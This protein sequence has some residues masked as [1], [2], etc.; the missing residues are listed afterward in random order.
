LIN[1]RYL[2][3]DFGSEPVD[4]E[5]KVEDILRDISSASPVPGGG[6]VAALSGSFGC[7]LISM[8]CNLTIGKT[9]Y[10][11]VESEFKD[12]LNE[13]EILKRELLDLSKKDVAAFNDVMASYK[14]SDEQDK[15]KKLQ[16]AYKNA[17]NVPYQTAKKCL[18]GLELAEISAT[19]G[20]QNAITDAGVG[21][22]LAYC[23]FQ[24]AILNV[25][26]NLKYT[27]DETFNTKMMLDIENHEKKA[28]DLL[29]TILD[30]IENT[31]Y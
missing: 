5:A 11:D 16:D 19:K 22:L 23:G 29:I 20:N 26:V 24:G 14:I 9:K 10:N 28:N 18:R 8:V 4:S 12:I 21:A 15:K 7:A 6:S 30:G 31:L 1:P 25:R 17:A 27:E 2:K 13:T 3:T